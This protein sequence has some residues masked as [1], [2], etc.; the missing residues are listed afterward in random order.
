MGSNYSSLGVM[1]KP[2]ETNVDVSAANDLEN[3]IKGGEQRLV[4]LSIRYKKVRES[5]RKIRKDREGMYQI[6]GK[7]L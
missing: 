1:K 2:K 5:G 7:K 6:S 4:L 3:S